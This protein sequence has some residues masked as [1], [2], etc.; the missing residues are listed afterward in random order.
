MSKAREADGV[1]GG[2]AEEGEDEADQMMEES[3]EERAIERQLVNGANGTR[4]SP[5]DKD[6]AEVES[7][8]K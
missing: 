2:G 5:A 6:R 4:S 1:E 8:A 3:D 7:I